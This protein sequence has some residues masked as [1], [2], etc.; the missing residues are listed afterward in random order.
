AERYGASGLAGAAS[1]VANR[2]TEAVSNTASRASD[3]VSNAAN[4]AT[5]AVSNA[6]SQVQRSASDL[7]GRASSAISGAVDQAQQKAGYI[8]ERAQYQA[9]RVEDTFNQTLNDNPVA[10]GAV[11]LALGTAVGLAL[12]QT[13]KENELMG[14]ARDALVD[15]AQT[16]AHD[17]IDQVQ[18]VAQK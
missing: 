3:A 11:A 12:P 2:A 4:R 1:S 5:S 16:A 14:S 7:A 15:K 8:A 9:R 6:A 13:R 10:L 17:A 18:Q